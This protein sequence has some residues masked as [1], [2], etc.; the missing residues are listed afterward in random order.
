MNPFLSSLVEVVTRGSACPEVVWSTCSTYGKSLRRNWIFIALDIYI[1][2][3]G[4]S[5]AK[6]LHRGQPLFIPE[7]QRDEYGTERIWKAFGSRRV[8]KI[9]PFGIDTVE[10]EHGL[11]PFGCH[12]GLLSGA[13][14]HVLASHRRPGSSVGFFCDDVEP[15]GSSADLSE[16]IV[17]GLEGKSLSSS[18]LS[19][20]VDQLRA[21]AW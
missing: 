4:S 1:N 13:A 12:Y 5:C 7:Q 17:A 9:S 8:I 11:N 10:A 6:Y 15:Q 2:E 18:D 14:Q 21:L 19:S 16:N 20:L 3:H